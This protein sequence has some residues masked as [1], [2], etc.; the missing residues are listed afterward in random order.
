MFL[1][2]N[3]EQRV[4]SAIGRQY[5]W[6]HILHIHVYIVYTILN[7][8]VT[9]HGGH[10]LQVVRKFDD[11]IIGERNSDAIHRNAFKIFPRRNGAKN[12]ACA[13]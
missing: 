5:E 10:S 12:N 7:S 9:A 4:L 2:N 3:L 11:D 13:P 1:T 8:Y 6:L